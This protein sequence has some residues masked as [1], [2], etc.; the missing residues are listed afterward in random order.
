MGEKR[1]VT[2]RGIRNPGVGQCLGFCTADLWS[3]LA[4]ES[5]KQKP[6]HCINPGFLIP[7]V[8][9]NIQQFPVQC[10]L[11]VHKNLTGDLTQD[12]LKIT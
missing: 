7:L 3:S 10:L 2:I 5:A 12:T 8:S 11:T 4:Y 9:I 6:K 1:N